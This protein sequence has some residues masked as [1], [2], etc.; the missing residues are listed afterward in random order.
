MECIVGAKI[1]T[2]KDHTYLKWDFK[3]GERIQNSLCNTILCSPFI[4]V[5]DELVSSMSEG[6]SVVFPQDQLV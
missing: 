3:G 1:L 4:F 2:E 6:V 5:F